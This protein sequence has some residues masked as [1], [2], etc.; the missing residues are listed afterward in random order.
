MLCCCAISMLWCG[1]NVSVDVVIIHCTGHCWIWMFDIEVKVGL[2]CFF[3]GSERM[4]TGYLWNLMS[5]VINVLPPPSGLLFKESNP[6]FWYTSN[7]LA[8]WKRAVITYWT[9]LW[10]TLE[11]WLTDGIFVIEQELSFFLAGLM[12]W[13]DVKFMRTWR[14]VKIRFCQT[15]LDIFKVFF[16]WFTLNRK[17]PQQAIFENLILGSISFLSID[18]CSQGIDHQTIWRKPI[19]ITSGPGE[20][21]Q[22]S[23]QMPRRTNL[24][25]GHFFSDENQELIHSSSDWR[26]TV[27]Q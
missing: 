24:L 23:W 14:T 10:W 21:V 13:C 16:S 5:H 1:D 19:S 2:E 6:F 8:D 7:L 12:I 15:R 25:S 20:I 22:V 9:Y 11:I 4:E 26:C 3:Y 17:W 27:C 18:R